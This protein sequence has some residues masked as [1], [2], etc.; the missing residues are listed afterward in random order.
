MRDGRSYAGSYYG[1]TFASVL[2]PAPSSHRPK[3]FAAQRRSGEQSDEDLQ[4][5][6]SVTTLCPISV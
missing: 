4:L 6:E 5:S 3:A 2:R 1:G